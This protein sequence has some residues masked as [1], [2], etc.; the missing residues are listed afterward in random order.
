MLEHTIRERNA[1]LAAMRDE[2][3]QTLQVRSHLGMGLSGW[4]RM[5]CRP[6]VVLGSCRM[7]A[8]L[9]G[10]EECL[11]IVGVSRW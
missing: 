1:D 6:Q 8:D 10:G 5:Q 7:T 3:Q 9:A 2:L 4:W 11:L